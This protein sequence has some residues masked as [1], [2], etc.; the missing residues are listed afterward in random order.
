LTYQ[1]PDDDDD[2]DDGDGMVKTSVSYRHLT[3]LIAQEDFIEFSQCKAQ[4]HMSL[5]LLPTQW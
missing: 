4:D 3:Q 5:F 1:I 2:D